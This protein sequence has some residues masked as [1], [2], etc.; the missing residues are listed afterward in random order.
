M[1]EYEMF[2]FNRVRFTM[3][4]TAGVGVCMWLGVAAQE[5]SQIYGV[6]RP[7]TKAEIDNWNIDVSPNGEGLP[8][9]DGT[10]KRGADLFASKCAACHGATGTEGPMDRLVDGQGTLASPQPIK[11]VGSYWPYAT[12]L[13]DYIYRAMPFS[14]PQS[15]T[16]DEVYSVIAWILYRNGI[17]AEDTIID[18]R[19][20]PNIQ[21]PNRYG[22]AP[23]PLPDVK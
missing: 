13:Y 4:V 23:D 11:T 22:F 14:S 5:P 19:S 21:M 2:T 3:L 18:A 7:A 12:T 16:P 10:A 20:L 8:A 6:G 17:I 1:E 15:L 9:G